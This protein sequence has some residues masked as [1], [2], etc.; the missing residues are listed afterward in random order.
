MPPYQRERV[1]G[2]LLGG[3]YIPALLE[4]F[5]AAED[6]EDAPSLASLYRIVRAMVLL[7]EPAVSGGH[8]CPLLQHAL[9]CHGHHAAKKH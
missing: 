6:L 3:A 1:A 4:V 7:N 8:A 9:P 2:Q 5:R